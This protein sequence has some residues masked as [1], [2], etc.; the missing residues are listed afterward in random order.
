MNTYC[1]K[2]NHAV[3]PGGSTVG[4]EQVYVFA[5]NFKESER[6]FLEKKGAVEIRDITYLGE[7]LN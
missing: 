5:P 1:I 6:I 7:A 4:Y 3:Y 2:F